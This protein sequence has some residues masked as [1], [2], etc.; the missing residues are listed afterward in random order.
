MIKS[1]QDGKE[2]LRATIGDDAVSN[3]DAILTSKVDDLVRA[4][5]GVVSSQMTGDGAKLKTA[6][7]KLL[8]GEKTFLG[9]GKP[10]PSMTGD[11]GAWKN[12][13]KTLGIRSDIIDMLEP[14]LQAAI[15]RGVDVSAL[16]VDPNN[17]TKPFSSMSAQEDGQ[18]GL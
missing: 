1:F 5:M 12:T 7:Q 15:S 6:I 10:T 16:F 3:L 18:P 14:V 4:E 8:G 2:D 13:A 17:P 9:F 11:L